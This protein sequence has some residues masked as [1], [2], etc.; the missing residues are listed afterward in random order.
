MHSSM[1]IGK[2]LFTSIGIMFALILLLGLVAVRSLTSLGA[3]VDRLIAVNVKKQQLAGDI[4]TRASDIVSLE[5]AIC[6][7]VLLKDQPKV[8]GYNRDVYVVVARLKKDLDEFEPLIETDEARRL[9][10]GMRSAVQIIEQNQEPLHQLATAG[11]VPELVDS[12]NKSVPAASQLHAGAEELTRQ[13][14]AL[15]ATVGNETHSSVARDRWLTLIMIGVFA[16]VGAAVV[17]IVR[18]INSRLRR[19][20]HE[21]D[22]GASQVA[23]AAGQV[24]SSSQS[25]AQGASEQAASLEETSASSEEISSMA[26]R[27]TDNSRS[28]AELVTD[29]GLKFVVTNKMLDQ[30]VVAMAEINLSS[31]KIAKI[32]KVID[33][34][35]FQTNI[36]ALNAAVEAARAGEAGMGFAV[37]A[38]EVRNLAQR[39]AQ[40]AKDTAALIEESIARSNEGKVQ[41]DQ[42]A[43]SIRGITTQA[44]GVKTLV[45]EVNLSSQE[46]ARGIEQIGKAITQMEQVT[47]KNAASA[48]ESASAAEELTAQSEA[49]HTIVEDLAAMVGRSEAAGGVVRRP[50]ARKLAARREPNRVT[51][52]RT[53][54]ESVATLSAAVSHPAETTAEPEFAHAKADR[55][56]LPLDDDDFKSF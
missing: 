33:E 47:Q 1:T 12:L 28:A 50:A 37:V 49:L 16:L 2:K 52:P 25:L 3:S 30:T 40:A 22:Q 54:S 15:L 14:A 29:S 31:G 38:D 13:E 53:A 17:W 5:R 32:I 55:S 45:D 9:L 39:S 24:S 46:Q 43:E 10:E 19:A 6:S 48:E 51:P 34:I 8:E 26:R 21:L 41:V 20:V 4:N 23:S 44:T 18:G 36:L 56:S 27:N 11:K 35:A 7:R 42:V